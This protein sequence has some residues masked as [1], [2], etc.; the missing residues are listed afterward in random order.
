LGGVITTSQFKTQILKVKNFFSARVSRALLDEF[1]INGL[2][3]TDPRAE[4]V[5]A[6]R[7]QSPGSNQLV[8]LHSQAFALVCAAQVIID[9]HPTRV[10]QQKSEALD[11][12]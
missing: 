6:I 8:H 5:K 10:G 9:H 1:A 7:L 11:E 4:A 3:P 2:P 12:E